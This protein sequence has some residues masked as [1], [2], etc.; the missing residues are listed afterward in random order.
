MFYDMFSVTSPLGVQGCPVRAW[1]WNGQGLMI[2]VRLHPLS[3]PLKISLLLQGHLSIKQQSS[4]IERRLGR[5]SCTSTCATNILSGWFSS[6]MK[7]NLMTHCQAYKHY[8]PKHSLQDVWRFI[9]IL[10]FHLIQAVELIEKN[11]Y[12]FSSNPRASSTIWWAL[13]PGPWPHHPV[14]CLRMAFTDMPI[15]VDC[16]GRINTAFLSDIAVKYIYFS[17]YAVS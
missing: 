12:F 11:I 10:P 8:N 9:F 16:R 14:L 13:S 15:R 17:E 4:N 1:L 5:A 2:A 7:F 6:I 3:S